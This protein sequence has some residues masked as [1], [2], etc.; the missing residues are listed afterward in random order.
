MIF[1]FSRNPLGLD[2]QEAIGMRLFLNG[3]EIKLCWFIDTE[4]GIVKTHDVLGDNRAHWSG[5][6][7]DWPEGT[8]LDPNKAASLTLTG[9]VEIREPI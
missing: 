1:D 7:L 9:V 6:K 8:E 3:T 5:E 4:A 2:E